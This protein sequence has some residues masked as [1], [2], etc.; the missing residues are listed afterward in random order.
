M[1][2]KLVVLFIV[3]LVMISGQLWSKGDA[4]AEDG[5]ITLEFFQQKREVIEIFDEIIA[6]FEA[7]NPGIIIEQSHVADSGQVLTS[8]M[9]TND[10]PAILT[11]WP[12]SVDYATAAVEDFFV[13]LTN[14][15]VTNGAL[16]S[17]LESIKLDNGKNYALPISINTQGIFYNVDLFNENNLEIPET[18]E[19]FISLCET[20]KNMGKTALVFPDNTTWTLSQQHRMSLELDLDGY[21]LIDAIKAG[22]DDCRTN[23]ELKAMAEKLYDLRAYGQDEPLG[24]SY[25]QAVFDFANGKAFMF[26]QGIWAIPSINSANPDLNYTMFALPALNGRETRVEYGVDLALVIGNTNERQIE[27]AKKFLAFVATP[28]IGQYYADIDG[29][30]SAIKGVAFNSEVSRPVVDYVQAGKSFRNIRFKFAPGGAARIATAYQ[31]YLI[32]HDYDAFAVEMNFG[33]GMPE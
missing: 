10:V 19:D 2:K 24:T 20:I 6:R 18:W 26:W 13:D 8:R 21:D 30:P 7:A 9:A 11:H 29:S 4:E 22:T 17:I 14:D 32:D 16:P 33:F 25:E 1:K 23:V 15:P 3:C 31:Q 12:N 5:V 27:A 28:E